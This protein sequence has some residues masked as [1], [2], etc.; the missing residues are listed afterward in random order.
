MKILI[1]NKVNRGMPY[2][3]AI[4]ELEKEIESIIENDVKSIE[5]V[6]M[7]KYREKSKKTKEI[8][9]N[10]KFKGEFLKLKNGK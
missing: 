9:K 8:A 4:K 3:D 7:K 5:R 1:Y 10:K 2:N 6:K